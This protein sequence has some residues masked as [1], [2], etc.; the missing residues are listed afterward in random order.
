MA[1]GWTRTKA[2]AR[3]SGVSERTFQKWLREG[4][5]H[6]RMSTEMILIRF[7]DIDAFLEGFQVADQN[8]KIDRIVS[9]VLR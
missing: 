8:A 9:E 2:A 1:S 5:V 7:A 3:Y 6:S 4:L